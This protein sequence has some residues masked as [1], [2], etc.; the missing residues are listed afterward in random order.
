MAIRNALLARIRYYR[1]VVGLPTVLYAATGR[2]TVRT[3]PQ[4]GAIGVPGV[5][6][7][8]VAARLDYWHGVLVPVVMHP[9]TGRRIFLVRNDIDDRTGVQEWLH[10]VN[11]DVLDTDVEVALPSPALGVERW[12]W[13][14]WPQDAYLPSGADVLAAIGDCAGLAVAGV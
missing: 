9:A 4:L 12:T 13:V 6:G 5:L 1:E 11:G 10:P 8:Q 14:D 7:G 2:I 3:S